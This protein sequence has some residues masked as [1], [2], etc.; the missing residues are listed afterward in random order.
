MKGK[1]A[2]AALL[3]LFALSACSNLDVVLRQSISS[4]D[5]VLKAAPDNVRADEEIAGWSVSA[6]DG[7]ARFIW[8]SDFSKSDLR[9]VMLE[10][11]AK[12]FV[13][14]GLDIEKLPGRFSSHDGKLV[15]GAEL[16]NEP[17][18][19]ADAP[20]EAYAQLAERHRGS[21]GFH[22]PMDHFNISLGEGD[23][24]EWAKDLSVNGS[25]QESQDK[26]IVFVLAPEPLAA[27]GADPEKVEGWSY[28]QVETVVDGKTTSVWKFLKPFD[29]R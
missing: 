10:F 26:D 28:A 23:M 20:L 22:T 4:F 3:A 21:I 7:S 27:A 9:D 12:P 6:P 11:D 13:D 15:V 19:G 25:S 8:S 1:F 2:A 29:L 17:G 24:F 14:A 5:E 16:G 18:N